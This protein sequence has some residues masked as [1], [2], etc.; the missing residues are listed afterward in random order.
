MAL[1]K[2]YQEAEEEKENEVEDDSIKM[3]RDEFISEH[4][5]LI[6]ILRKGD[7]KELDAEADSQQEE[8]D[9]CLNEDDD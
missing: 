9:E 8:L 1:N 5:R 4:K 3:E 6:K 2:L 7:R